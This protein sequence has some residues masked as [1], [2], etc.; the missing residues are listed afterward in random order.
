M[1]SHF[2][3]LSPAEAE[4]LACLMEECGEVVQ[5]IG[6]VLR[7]GY[8]DWSPHDTTRT[9]NRTNLAREV[10]DLSAVIDTMRFA[11]DIGDD[12]ITAAAD[13]KMKKLPLWTHHQTGSQLAEA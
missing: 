7:H 12:T 9:T 11:N 6:K 10:G 13:A 2:N 1:T 4:R 5:M 8:E 3:K